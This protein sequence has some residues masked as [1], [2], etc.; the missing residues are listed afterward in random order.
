M[1]QQYLND[2]HRRNSLACLKNQESLKQRSLSINDIIA[3]S[4]RLGRF[5]IKRTSQTQTEE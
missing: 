4:Q 2:F 1:E 5:T 3:Q